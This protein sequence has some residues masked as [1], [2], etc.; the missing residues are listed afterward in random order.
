[1]IERAWQSE[2]A[3][4]ITAQ[5][6]KWINFRRRL[7]Q[8][9][10]PSGH[11]YQ[12]S[13]AIYQELSS[14]GVDLR[15]GPEGRGVLSDWRTPHA[16]GLEAA[17]AIRGDIDALRIHDQKEVPYHSLCPGLMHACG[18]DAHA[19][20]ALWATT[21]IV[22]LDRAGALPWP[23]RLRSIF[24]PAEETCTGA[25]EMISVGA[26]KDV[27]EIYA[28]HVDPT[29]PTGRIGLRVGALTASCDAVRILI[30]GQ[31]GHGARPHESRDPIAASA[32]LISALYLSIPR[33][34]DSQDA[35]VLTFG[36]IHGGEN[37]N[38]IPEQVELLGTLRTLDTDVRQRTI[39]HIHRIAS[40]V[41]RA[42]DT[43]IEVCFDV[44]T[45][46]VIN[47]AKPISHLKSAIV[48]S[49]GH[50]AIYEI[51]RASMGGED[52]AFYLDHVPGAMA[53]LGCRPPAVEHAP[54]LHSPMFDI[55]EAV[56]AI[57]ARMLASA[58]IHAFEPK[59][60]HEQL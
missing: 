19:T 39:D 55:D 30:H 40:G 46:A 42:T 6:A 49:F 20:M 48:E 4:M 57:G 26:L 37:L 24:Q 12:T 58:A 17:I 51:P 38:V 8:N 56:L 10:E 27:R 52:F 28:T 33:V 59:P 23:L 41:Q 53:R 45:S 35:V 7:H 22:E 16:E 15:M 50:E 14:L 3:A 47:Q 18:H 1:M 29:L 25:L 21:L 54:L 2:L 60:A 9:P 36:R 43:T 32:Q 34:T 5:E 13:L 11:E 31:G 44:G